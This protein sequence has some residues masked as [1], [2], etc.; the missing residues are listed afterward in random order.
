MIQSEGLYDRGYLID[1][2]SGEIV[3]HRNNLKYV[4]SIDD[5]YYPIAYGDTLLSIARKKYG[6]S[7]LWFF[8][9]DVN[10]NIEDIFELPE[11]D[12]ILIPSI[13]LI[14]SF[15]ARIR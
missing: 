10:D 2:G 6:F 3:V 1:F 12:T 4:Q 15:Y 5:E 11:G 14:Q 9:A 13:S 7:S 8:I